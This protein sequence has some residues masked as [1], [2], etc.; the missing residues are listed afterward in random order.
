[1]NQS[2]EEPRKNVEEVLASNGVRELTKAVR[3]TAKVQEPEAQEIVLEGT[4]DEVN[5]FF[6]R[7]QW[8]DGLPFIPPTRERIQTFLRFT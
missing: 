4:L 3:T 1:M 7:R 5:E 2:Q 8:T 6:L